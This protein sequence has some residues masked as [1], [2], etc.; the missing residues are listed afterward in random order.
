M[1]YLD[2][3]C[4]LKLYYPEPDSVKVAKLVSSQVVALVLLHELEMSNALDLKLFRKDARPA[5]IRATQALVEQDI[6]AGIFHRPQVAW[7]EVLQDARAL[8][9]AHTRAI[10]CR[11][12][13]L[14][15]CAIARHVSASAFITTDM[16]QRR[17]A[18]A[19]GLV[20]PTV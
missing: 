19:I 3:G 8:A 17:V 1:T 9:K 7:D 2:T 20:C 11:S 13:D 18:M 12:L 5:Q 6:R 14:L 4:L 15:H 10:G 16:R